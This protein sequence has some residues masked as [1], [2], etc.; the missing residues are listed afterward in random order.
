MFTEDRNLVE[1]M[2]QQN[3]EFLNL[4]RTHKQLEKK[5]SK[6]NKR[7]TLTPQEELEKKQLQKEKLVT[8]DQME[9]LIRSF[10]ER[11][12]VGLTPPGRAQGQGAGACLPDRQ[13]QEDTGA[14]DEEVHPGHTAPR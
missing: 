14:L 4:Q 12:S 5:L 7:K 2:K 3:H 1:R 10:R 9:V 13:G 11:E 8:K 6:L